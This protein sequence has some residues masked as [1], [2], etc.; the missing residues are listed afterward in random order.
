MT[1]TGRE[2][3]EGSAPMA[4]SGGKASGRPGGVT[5]AMVARRAGVSP[6]TV[7]NAINAPELL[8]PDT[9]RRVRQAIDA[10]GYRPHRAAQQ[11]RTRSS[12]LIGYGIR[13]TAPGTP[14]PVLDHFL[15]ALSQTADAAGH[16]ILLFAEPEPEPGPE[17][18]PGPVPDGPGTRDVP[19]RML[20]AYQEL[21]DTYSVDGFVLSGTFRGDPRQVW[22][23]KQGIPFAAFGRVWSGRETG[24]WVDVDG[25]AGTE[26]LT[27]HLVGLGHARIAFLGWPKGSGSGDDRAAGWRRAMR[28]H[29]LPVRGRRAACVDDLDAARAAAGPLLDAGATAVVAASDTLALGCYRAL[30]ERGLAPGADVSVAG[31]DDSPAAALLT[32]ALTSV[33]QPLDA[34]GRDC[35]RMLLGRIA[36]PARPP[37][38]VLL[39]PAL[40]IRESTAPPPH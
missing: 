20:D 37:A 4:D 40:S 1:D 13:P 38:H 2:A 27:D 5:L 11:L 18:G 33:A 22:L 36:E 30:R 24:D 10:M 34:V 35:V 15:H 17:P 21:L 29:G 3:E 9:L 23:E 8:R 39:T 25:A 7:S 28:R 31:F 12:K 26:A 6:Q 14:T 32:P 19:Q 16:R